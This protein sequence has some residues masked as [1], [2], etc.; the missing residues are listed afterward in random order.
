MNEKPFKTNPIKPPEDR[1]SQKNELPLEKADFKNKIE[2]LFGIQLEEI[3]PR[4]QISILKFLATK[5]AGEVASIAQEIC[6]FDTK[7]DRLNAFMTLLAHE[8][9]EAIEGIMYLYNQIPEISIPLYKKYAE[10]IS[11]LDEITYFLTE[12]FKDKPEKAVVLKIQEE[13]IQKANEVLLRYSARVHTL[14]AMEEFMSGVEVGEFNIDGDAAYYTE[15][16]S[17]ISTL[18]LS[19]LADIEKVS[20]DTLL[21]LSA[22]RSLI[23]GNPEVSIEDIKSS[24]LQSYT[25]EEIRSDSMRETVKEMRLMYS[26]NVT[27]DNIRALLLAKFAARI[28]DPENR[29]EFDILYFKNSLLAF[30][31]FTKEA[32]GTYF[33]SGLNVTPNMQGS[34]IGEVM[35]RETIVQKTKVADVRGEVIATKDVV[36]R[37]LK[38]GAI[39]FGAETKYGEVGMKIVWSKENTRYKTKNVVGKTDDE[40]YKEIRTLENRADIHT[41][42]TE[43]QSK[44]DFEL[45][46]AGYVI[47]HILRLSN[48]TFSAIFERNHVEATV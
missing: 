23:K 47:T 15:T 20:K 24:R 26:S 12:N 14:N 13:L 45:T 3:P 4:I 8:N 44:I 38:D 34:G 31:V 10:I 27:N 37:Y 11:D 25:S 39:M 46:N 29:S 5:S 17:D 28:A 2:A 7:E 6:I 32:D 41:Q 35:M 9:F 16:G 30:V 1:E 22:F 33:A 21:L 18:K 19:I 48:G 36:R 43:D 40:K 42:D